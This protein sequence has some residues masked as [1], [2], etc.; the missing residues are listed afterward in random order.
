MAVSIGVIETILHVTDYIPLF[1]SFRIEATLIAVSSQ[2]FNTAGKSNEI[3]EATVPDYVTYY[4][5][6]SVICKEL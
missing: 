2:E 5:P 3:E 6:K 1:P 4:L